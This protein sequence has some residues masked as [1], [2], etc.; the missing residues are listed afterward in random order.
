M[1]SF[2][3]VQKGS[4]LVGEE[5]GTELFLQGYLKV[6]LMASGKEQDRVFCWREIA[7]RTLKY[8]CLFV[9]TVYRSLLGT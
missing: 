9:E 6:M 7:A 5:S 3:T 4:K 8:R 1:A 2:I